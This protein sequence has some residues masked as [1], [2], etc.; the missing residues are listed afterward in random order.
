[1]QYKLHHGGNVLTASACSLT[2]RSL[3]CAI[4]TKMHGTVW[5]PVV[6]V[7]CSERMFFS[8]PVVRNHLKLAAHLQNTHQALHV[9]AKTHMGV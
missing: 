4:I 2:I 7:M 5:L 8:A 3:A 1:M 6:V 9:P